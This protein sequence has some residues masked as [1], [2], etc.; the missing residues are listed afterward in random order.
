[1]DALFKSSMKYT[2]EEYKK[3]TNAVIMSKTIIAVLLLELILL[4]TAYIF[5]NCYVLIVVAI[6]PIIFAIMQNINIK[7]IYNSNKIMQNIDVEY[8][9]YE[10]YFHVKQPIGEAKI[11]YKKLSK[12]IET[13]TNFYLMIANNQGYMLLKDNMSEELI[14]FIRDKSKA[15]V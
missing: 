14:S 15:L 6:F 11:E 2:Y 13:K 1:M 12:I 4:A 7:R 10:D 5:L 3:F 8:E 9:F